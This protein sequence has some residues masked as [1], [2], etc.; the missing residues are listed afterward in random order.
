MWFLDFYFEREIEYQL[1][2]KL[3]RYMSTW[4][5]SFLL[6]Y[7]FLE[8]KSLIPA[9]KHTK[10]FNK[11]KKVYFFVNLQKIWLPENRCSC[12]R[13]VAEKFLNEINGFVLTTFYFTWVIKN[14]S[15]TFL[16]STWNLLLNTWNMLVRSRNKPF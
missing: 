1:I 5:I 2:M 7:R 10:E 11:Q 6:P 15:F 4:T 13:N 14:C 16:L 9:N 3:Y 8:K 12:T